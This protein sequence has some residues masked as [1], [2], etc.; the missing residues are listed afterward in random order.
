MERRH[1]LADHSGWCPLHRGFT[2]RLF[3][4]LNGMG[5]AFL[6]VYDPPCGSP[7]RVLAASQMSL[8]LLATAANG[9]STSCGRPHR[10]AGWVP[11]DGL[12]WLHPQQCTLHVYSAA[13]GNTCV[14]PLR[15]ALVL[16]ASCSALPL[17]AA[18]SQT[19][20]LAFFS[21]VSLDGW[22]LHASVAGWGNEVVS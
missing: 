12:K 2:S 14:R 8:R 4:N 19:P 7:L 18:F 3:Q 20:C 10:S 11:P 13:V 15:P 17:F 16:P 1:Q 5:R 22:S 21:A 6:L 9:G